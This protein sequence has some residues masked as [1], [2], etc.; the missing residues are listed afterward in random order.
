MSATPIKMPQLSDTM[1]EGVLVTWCKQ[2]GD[3]IR[4]GD[5]VA[6]VETDKAIMDVEVFRDGFLSGPIVEVGAT[7]PVGGDLA[8]IVGAES[9][10]QR[11]T[12]VP[13]AGAGTGAHG[14]HGDHGHDQAAPA[15]SG[16]MDHRAIG[17]RAT[18]ADATVRMVSAAALRDDL[19]PAPRPSHAPASPFARKVAAQLGVDLGGVSPGAGTAWIQSA[20]VVAAARTGRV[21]TGSR[22]TFAPAAFDV[23]GKGRPMTPIEAA[24]A[25]TMTAALSMPTF[26]VTVG[27]S[28]SALQRT[29]KAAKVSMTVAIARGCALAIE[30][31]PKVNAAWQPGDRIVERDQVDVGIAVAAEG[32]LVVPVLRDAGGRPLAA[33][34]ASWEDLVARA[35][36]RRLKPADWEHPTFQVSNMGMLGVDHFDAIPV[37]GTAC[38][39]AISTTGADGKAAFCLT[40]DHRVVNGADAAAFLGTLKKR[41]EAPES[42]LEGE[43][44]RIPAGT[45]DFDVI[46]VGGGPGGEDCARDLA[47]QGKRVAM[48]NDAPFP[49]GECLWRGC[50]PSKAW[51]HA[52]DRIRDRKGDARLGIEGTEG[53]RLRWEVLEQSRRAVLEGRGDMALKTDRAVKVTYVQGRASFIGAHELI[54]DAAGA[55]SDPHRRAGDG[56]ETVRVADAR[57]LTFGCAVIATG[58]PP[59]IPPVPGLREGTEGGAV[60]TSDSVWFLPDRPDRVAI[61]GCGAIGAEMAQMFADFGSKVLILEAKDRILAEVEEE[62]ARELAAVFVDEPNIRLHAGVKVLGCSGPPG[63][64]RLRYELADGSSHDEEVDRVLVATG[65]RPVL[66]GLGL[67]ALGLQPE[68]G[69]IVVDD[70]CRTQVPHI[71]AVGDVV[72]G[73]MLAHTAGQQGRVAAAQILGHDLRY[74]ESKDCG[75]IFTR[76]QAA[77][78]GLTVAAAKARGFDA[79]EVKSPV[80]LDAKAMIAGEEH[81]V[82]KIVADAK[83]KRILG[84]HLLADHADT[85]VGEAVLM[86][87]CGLTL[88]QV[89]QAIHPHPTQCEMWGEMARRLSLRL[90]RRVSK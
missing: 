62:V 34:G 14:G 31:H 8:Y 84:A 33:L 52:A 1:T 87:S 15:A 29:A 23:P 76:P 51:R 26:R 90:A 17:A 44:P 20:D 24:T 45:W 83:S 64:V 71:Y 28:L 36:T 81:G 56:T 9:E 27:I 80:R 88:D 30:Q 43:G 68:R 53:A 21:D 40:S 22:P 65:K 48:V 16:D 13:T 73:Y 25:R 3:A 59:W 35:R 66:D 42:W 32:G 46:V 57:R 63:Q 60:L 18:A 41:L 55:S 50:I 78:V 58:A 10:V 11:G 6:N 61:V 77:F 19:P 54:V 38:I 7:V 49:G 74:D 4:R 75:V 86:V 39:L 89:G 12:M 82:L 67:A 72:G 47:Q 2:P 69:V 37:V 5:I 70:R 79:V 85:L